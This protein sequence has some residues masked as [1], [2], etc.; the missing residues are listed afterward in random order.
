MVLHGRCG[1]PR[2]EAI[3]LG[4]VRAYDAVGDGRAGHHRTRPVARTAARWSY[5]TCSRWT[6]SDATVTKVKPSARRLAAL[7]PSGVVDA[8]G[9][10]GGGCRFAHRDERGLELVR[11]RWVGG[12]GA[13]D[14]EAQVGGADV[15]AV[16]AGG[17]ADLLDVRQAFG[18]L[19]HGEHHGLWRGRRRGPG[20]CAGRSASGR[21]SGCPAAG[22]GGGAP[23]RRRPLRCRRA[24]RSRR[25]RRRPVPCRSAWGRWPPR[26]PCR[27]RS[28]P[29]RRSR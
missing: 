20:R 10:P 9:Y 8:G 29:W 19:D 5:A 21:T 27:R 2:L 3:R 24:G 17:G 13:A 15:D 22:S 16:E 12:A 6:R 26:A 18:G 7:A 28:C 23:R 4:G 1:Q 11:D 25:P 14:G